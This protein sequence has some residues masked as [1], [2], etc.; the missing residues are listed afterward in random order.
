MQI[1]PSVSGI[2]DTDVTVY[3]PR[4]RS[5]GLSQSSVLGP[6]PLSVFDSPPLVSTPSFGLSVTAF[7]LVTGQSGKL[8]RVWV[9]FGVES[10]SSPDR[11][12]PCIY[13]YSSVVT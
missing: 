4:C 1:L 3:G 10:G 7:G 12:T 6:P 11:D 9:Q 8:V 13:A 2:S 5:L